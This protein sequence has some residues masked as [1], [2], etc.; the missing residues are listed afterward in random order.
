M[1][2]TSKIIQ[3]YYAPDNKIIKFSLRKYCSYE[4]PVDWVLLN[5]SDML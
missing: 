4:N 5:K 2:D 1:I 3:L